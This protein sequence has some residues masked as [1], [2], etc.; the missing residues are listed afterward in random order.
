MLNIIKHQ[1]NVK[2][3]YEDMIYFNHHSVQN[4]DFPIYCL[5][6]LSVF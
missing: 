1:A 4:T 6:Y 5:K 3:N 2:Q